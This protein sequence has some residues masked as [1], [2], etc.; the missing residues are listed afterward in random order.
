MNNNIRR[1]LIIA[2]LFLLFRSYPAS[3]QS[4]GNPYAPDPRLYECMEKSYA[5]QLSS[6]RPELI[7]YYNYYLDHS[8][9]VVSLKLEKPVTGIDIHTVMLSGGDPA[10]P[11]YFAEKK[12]IAGKFNPMKYDFVRAMDSFTTYI[13]KEAGIA[14]EFIPMRHFQAQFHDYLKEINTNE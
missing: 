6:G 4:S 10:H 8:Y 14:I 13:W 2:F 7:L 9:N 5:D 12:Y 1:F 3:S 11:A